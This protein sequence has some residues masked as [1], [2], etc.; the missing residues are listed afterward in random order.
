M[1]TCLPRITS[2]IASVPLLTRAIRPHQ[3]LRRSTAVS[4]VLSFHVGA[5]PCTLGNC[6]SAK[7]AAS[8]RQRRDMPAVDVPGPGRAS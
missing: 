5:C 2:R 4:K 7:R 8:S 6:G 1:V 3:S